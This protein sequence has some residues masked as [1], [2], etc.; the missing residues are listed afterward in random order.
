MKVKEMWNLDEDAV[1]ALKALP[2]TGMGF[3]LVEGSFWGRVAPLLVFNTERAYDLST[4]G[5]EPGDDPAT[6]LRNG[7][8]IVELLKSEIARTIIAAPSPRIHGLLGSRIGTPPAAPAA[9][10]ATGIVTALP[11]SLVKH[12]KLPSGRT[13]HRFS[14]FK[15]DPRIDPVTGDFLP[16]TY[17]AP[18]SEVPFVQTGFVAVG[19]FA[20]PVNLPA[21]HHYEIVAPAGTHVDFGTVAPAFGQ[22]GGGVE[23]YFAGAVTNAQSPPVYSL[24][25][26]E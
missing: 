4:I 5:L 2:E 21:S 13:F 18:A 8:K 14:A 25:P 11:S 9:T 7:L 10:A 20:L 6:I 3:Q 23:A 17:A 22:S 15:P 12:L 19:R 24:M 26:D 1:A 16:G